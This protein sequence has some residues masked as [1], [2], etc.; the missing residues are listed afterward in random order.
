[1]A[2]RVADAFVRPPWIP[3]TDWGAWSAQAE[4]SGL[5]SGA[6]QGTQTRMTNAPVRPGRWPVV[7]SLKARSDCYSGY[8]GVA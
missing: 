7:A 6:N 8:A 1:M 5:D 2:L 4:G 3:L